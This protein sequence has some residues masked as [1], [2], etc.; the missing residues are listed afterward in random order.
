[1]YH[2]INVKHLLLGFGNNT[3]HK[4]FFYSIQDL[5]FFITED[6]NYIFFCMHLN[7]L[8]MVF[9]FC[10]RHIING[11]L[12]RIMLKCITFKEKMKCQT[13]LNNV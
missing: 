11:I 7:N 2:E 10:N 3:Y 9:L 4:T 1:M 8:I 12:T 13:S 5:N 6:Y